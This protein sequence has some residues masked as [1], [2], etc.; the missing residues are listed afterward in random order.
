MARRVVVLLGLCGLFLGRGAAVAQPDADPLGLLGAMRD[1]YERID[2]GTAERRAREALDMHEAF[3]ADQLVEVHTLLGLILYARNEPLEAREQFEAALSLDP[4]LELDP[5]LVSPKTLEFFE[6]VRSTFTV[7]GGGE[8]ESVIRYVR[9]HDPRPAA[10]VR[11]VVLPGWGQLYKGERAKGWVLVGL[12][13]ATAAGTVTAHVLRSQARSDY[14]DAT[15]PTVIAERYDS[16]NTWHQARTALAL[17]AVAVWTYAAFD[18]LV[19]GGPEERTVRLGPGPGAGLS[20]RV[21]L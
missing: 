5:V 19:F 20:L 13:G 9:V 6:E 16:F 15:D 7:E 8:R 12:W 11:S 14:L 21:A 17:G 10:T 1:A 3:S 2:Y 18:A 4:A